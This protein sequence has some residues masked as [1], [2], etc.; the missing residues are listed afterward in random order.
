M[1]VIPSVKR[2]LDRRTEAGAAVTGISQMDPKTARDYFDFNMQHSSIPARPLEQ[3]EAVRIE[4]RDGAQ[5]NGR[6]YYPSQ[7]CWGDPLPALLYFH[8]GGYVVGSLATADSLC[9][10]L[11][12][13]TQCAVVS[14]HYRLAPEYKF[15]YAVNDALDS[16]SWL[17]RVAWSL[18]LD[19]E[20]LAVGG[21]SSGATLAAVCAVHARD[22]GIA[23]ALQMLI[24]PALSARTDTLAHRR[25]G[26]GYF[27][28]VPVIQWIHATYLRSAE[29]AHDWRF[30]PLDGDRN[31]PSSWKGLAPT[32]LVSA[33][34]DPLQDEHAGY[35]ARLRSHGNQVE[36]RFY[37]SM[38][39]GFFSMG[40]LIP[41]AA[42]AHREAV[43]ALREAFGIS[44]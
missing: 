7:P 39:H 5:L 16:L 22:A 23:L 15:P 6:I 33:E 37:P 13:D 12:A 24:Y 44:A 11:A 14:V 29:D 30:A 17:H 35:A 27:L 34:Y 19:R 18:G 8:S 25:Y 41:E 9:R 3:I 31:A 10:M 28:T 4:M 26:E 32:W 20:R 38:I 43:G 42:V 1:S 36:I 21:E 2:F 40:G